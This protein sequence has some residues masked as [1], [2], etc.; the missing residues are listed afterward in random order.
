MSM[1]EFGADANFTSLLRIFRR[2]QTAGHG[3]PHR[4]E[5]AGQLRNAANVMKDGPRYDE[6]PVK[7]RLQVGVYRLIAPLG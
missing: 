3:R 2:Q 1:L 5:I 7:A 4:D 6:V